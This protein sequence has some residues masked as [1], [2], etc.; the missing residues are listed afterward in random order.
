MGGQ[1]NLLYFFPPFNYAS[2]TSGCPMANTEKSEGYHDF[3]YP[4]FA[5]F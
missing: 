1:S 2:R 4:I 3:K 5:M